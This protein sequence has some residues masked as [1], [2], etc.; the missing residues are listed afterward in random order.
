MLLKSLKLKDFRQF[1]G[2]QTID[3]ATDSQKNV[4]II[5]GENGSGK[6]SLAQ[7]FTWCL[8]G[9][10]DFED[11][12]LLCKATSQ[13]ML[14]GQEETVRAELALT[15][16]GTDY[17][18]I[19]EQRYKKNATGAIQSVG[20]RKFVIAFK[21]KDGQ[22]EFIPEL[23]SELRMKEILPNELSKYFFFDGERIG[24]MSKELR[25]G[26]SRE[27]A[28][29]VR[30][31]LGLSAFT[32]AIHHLK[33]RGTS[34]SVLR[35]YDDKY[36]AKADN[37]INEYTQKI[38]QYNAEI[39]RIDNRLQE[40]ESED[41]LVDEKIRS[42]SESIKK[43]EDS[44]ELADRKAVLIQRRQTLI[45]RRNSQTADLIK[46]FNKSAPA[47]FA[48]K[49]MCD[50]LGQLAESHKLDKG[51]PDIHARTIDHIINNGRC[52]CGTEVRVGNEAFNTLNHLRDYIPP[53]ALGN[54]IGQFRLQC[55]NSVKNTETFFD[56]FQGKFGEIRSF[57]GDFNDNEEE[58]SQITKRLEGMEDVGKLQTELNKYERQR[59]SLQDERSNLDKSKGIT[60]TSR[61]RME[62][63]R[64]ELTLK[65]KNNRQIE[66]YKAYAQYLHEYIS[67]EYESEEARVREEL[68]K[69]VDEIF[70][71]IYN[72]G[73]SLDLD[74]KYN[75]QVSVNDHEGYTDDIETS[76]AQSISIIFAFIAG[77]IKMARASQNP[78]NA[79]LVSE[80]YPLVMDAPLSAFDK[81]RIQTVCNVLPEVAE[82]VIIF[83]K[84]TDGELAETHLSSRIGS[85]ATFSKS[86]EFETYIEERG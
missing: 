33:G 55:E 31:L 14:P 59:R 74:D 84:D 79:V 48:K 49:M 40:I 52:I 42:L 45:N 9:K 8:Y 19:S 1:K 85:R 38:T 24:N 2:E 27:F 58:I 83:I 36:D 68:S 61:D 18:V 82:Q 80:P 86:N 22:Q 57:D 30:S 65:D 76:T 73:F 70:R 69:A 47:Y 28:E 67:S 25:K 12:M 46:I 53:Q 37:R 15:H 34:K 11:P 10:T 54:L 4:T 43:N 60:E 66:I 7:A 44:K 16:S 26:K 63:E 39:E 17:T 77:V 78:E 3:F 51:V 20:Q 75:V 13:L 6:T 32:S 23:K 35:N 71:S 62:T 29:A 21:G 5:L 81:T 41:D 64:H 56:D 50:S 72:G